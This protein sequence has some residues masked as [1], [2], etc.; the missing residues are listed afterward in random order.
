[1][2]IA[3]DP[4]KD[5]ANIAK[6]GVSLALAGELEVLAVVED[7]RRDYGEVRKRAFGVIDGVFFSLAYTLRDGQVRAI[8]LRRAH[9]KEIDRYVR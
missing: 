2:A 9:Q 1:M 6:H 7:D 8:S 3:F 5:A 4:A